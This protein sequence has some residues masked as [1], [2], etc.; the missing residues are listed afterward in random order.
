LRPPN[1]HAAA[2]GVNAA[3]VANFYR[4]SDGDP[5][6]NGTTL[7]TRYK[8]DVNDFGLGITFH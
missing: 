3:P 1:N 6:E 5:K 4:R 7:D 2:R 8:H